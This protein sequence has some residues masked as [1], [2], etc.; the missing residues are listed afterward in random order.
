MRQFKPIPEWALNDQLT[1]SPDHLTGCMTYIKKLFHAM[2]TRVNQH[3]NQPAGQRPNVPQGPAVAVNAAA[4][5]N[6]M[7]ALNANNLQ[8]L[9]QQE[10]AVR[11][12]RASSQTTSGNAPGL[13]PAPFG[14]PSPRGVPHAYGPGSMPPEKLK[15]PPPKKRKQSHAGVTPGQ[16]PTPGTPSSKTPTNKPA[17]TAGGKPS[18]AALAGAF[19]CGVPDC[20]HHYYGFATQSALD[21]HIEESH[22]VEETIEDPL[23]FALE[24]I[25]NSLVKEEKPEAPSTKKGEVP[26]AHHKSPSKPEAKPE[27]MTPATAGATPMG[28]IPSQLGV[29][30]ASPASNQQMTP[31]PTSGK[32]PVAM[33]S[34]VSKEG[35]K[36]TGKTA[37]P[38][39]VETKD[40]WADSAISLEAIHDTFMDFG[41]EGLPGL[42]VDPMEEF[43]NSDMFSNPQTQDTPE[44]VEAGAGTQTPK[45]GE[46]SKEEEMNVNIGSAPDE[47]WIP[48]DWLCLP[49]R[50]EDDFLVSGPGEID[51][52]SM[53]RKDTDMNDDTG[54]AI[55]AM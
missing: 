9:Q 10:E 1:I 2:I 46:L 26:S 49:S 8:Q 37:E 53:D 32:A 4:N 11:A 29:K 55:Y 35:K 21:K 3:Q 41:N 20:Q 36:D 23:E 45:D 12:R 38:F 34:T 48:A 16:A 22:K 25:R 28:R 39:P 44:S 51:W 33:K 18:S 50:F 15:L 30:S 14:A 52:D 6:N 17:Q 43:L 7:P 5:Q 24:S 13:P 47:N 40:P 31:R 42:G 54:I 19:K 27:G